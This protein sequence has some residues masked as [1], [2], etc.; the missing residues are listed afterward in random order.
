MT[1]INL[2]ISIDILVLRIFFSQF[3]KAK[4]I[5]F[6]ISF[7]YDKINFPLIESKN[8]QLIYTP[9]GLQNLYNKTTV[10]TTERL[11]ELALSSVYRL[12]FPLL[13]KQFNIF[14]PF[15]FTSYMML[16]ICYLPNLHALIMPKSKKKSKRKKKR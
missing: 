7:E 6:E 3:L 12:D 13:L 11:R 9:I 10:E 2:F 16:I 5:H 15:I 1:V 8:S 14:L 4:F